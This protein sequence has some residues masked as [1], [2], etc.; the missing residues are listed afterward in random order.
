MGL[1]TIF[2]GIMNTTTVADKIAK[3]QALCPDS[4][5][6]VYVVDDWYPSCTEAGTNKLYVDCH[7]FCCFYDGEFYARIVFFGG[8]DFGLEKEFSSPNVSEVVKAYR[9]FRKYAKKL[10]HNRE[11]AHILYRDGFK[12]F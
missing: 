7:V 2:D 11:L 10:P 4:C 5:R 3:I 6:K 8:D 9:R 1:Q 12:P